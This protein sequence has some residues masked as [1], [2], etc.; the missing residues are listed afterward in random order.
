MPGFPQLG[1]QDMTEEGTATFYRSWK[2][3]QRSSWL[4]GDGRAQH[5]DSW[6]HF[7]YIP[8]FPVLTLALERSQNVSSVPSA[9]RGEQWDHG[10]CPVPDTG[11]LHCPP[12]HPTRDPRLR[13]LWG[14]GWTSG[15]GLSKVRDRGKF[16]EVTKWWR[17]NISSQWFPYSSHL[18]A[19]EGKKK[20]PKSFL[21][22]L[23]IFVS[24]LDL[25]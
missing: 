1:C 2:W 25:K 16:V 3:G 5:I 6:A 21:Q 10:V 18:H 14:F 13:N 8:C 9:Q 11:L 7:L 19:L 20:K 23:S 15:T 24:L 4:V 12:H 22:P 17:T